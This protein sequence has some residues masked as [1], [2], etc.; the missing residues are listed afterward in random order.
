VDADMEE[1]SAR[2]SALQTRQQLAIQTLQI[3]NESPK[4]LL[5]LFN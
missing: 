1:A 3:S 4:T 2:L 5:S